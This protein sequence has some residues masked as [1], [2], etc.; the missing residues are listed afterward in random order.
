M[1]VNYLKEKNMNKTGKILT[2]IIYEVLKG[3]PFCECARHE[4]NLYDAW[5][6][7]ITETVDMY[8]DDEK[9]KTK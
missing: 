7:R 5:C 3:R 8:L 1:K 2:Q 4:D 6:L 9:G